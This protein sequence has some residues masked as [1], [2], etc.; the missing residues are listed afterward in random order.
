MAK[1]KGRTPEELSRDAAVVALLERALQLN[2]E[3]CFARAE[4]LAPCPIGVEGLCCRHCAMGP[5]RLVGKAERGVCGATVDTVVARNFARAVAAGA[6]AHSDHGRDLAF[7]LLEA[8]EGQ[9]S[10]YRIRDPFKLKEVA[11]Y[12]GVP[13][14]G[15]PIRDI[16]RD[17]ALAALGE[18]GRTHGELLY[19][20]RAPAKRQKI[21]RDLHIAPRAIDREVVELLHRTNIGNDQDPEHLLD[22]A[23]RC[24]LADGWG[25]S[26][27]ATDLTD[28]LFG[29]PA[30]VL[31]EANL[32]VLEED[33]VNIIIH[34]HEPTL[35]EMI[36]AAAQD[37]ELI[38][39]ARSKGAT[40]INL[41][42]ICCTA[43]EALMRQGVPLAGNFL[44]QELAILTG[45]VEAMVVDV[46]CIMQGLVP[47]ASRFHTEIITT[48]RKAKIVG[49]TH[50]EFDE[51]RA[52]EIAKEIIRR[53]IDR[54]PLRDGV[55]IPE[56]RTPLVPGFS[57]E[58]IGYALGGFYRGSFRPLNDAII[59]GRI[60]GVVANIGC[61][62]ARVCHDELHRYV[63]S[64]FLKNDV[65]VVETGCGA[66]AGAKAGF[67]RPEA[68]LELAGPGLR[69]VCEAVGIPPVLHLGACVDNSRILTVLS[70]MAT[71]T[72]LGED[73][74]D[75]PAVGMAPEWMSEKALAIATYCVASGAYVIMGG[76]G[77][78]RG[79]AEVTRLISEGWEKKVGGK[80]EF[81]PDA[82]EIVRRALAH[83]DQKRAALGLA[84]YDPSKWGKSGDWRIQ[85]ILALPLEARLEAI[86]GMSV[87]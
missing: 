64:E 72:G 70:Q 63:V 71:E 37:P 44:Q 59:A 66:I 27:L 48:S 56:A 7:T 55:F 31:S 28:I 23:M 67:M 53:A 57:H 60:R 18:F 9:A 74:A 81:I 78:V 79:S 10:D 17:V 80:L 62:N 75:I 12:L 15:R 46:Q 47:I 1:K 42:G 52:L 33:M 87:N 34:G 4:E 13:V 20:K 21:W 73:I 14:D 45:A 38:E 86:Y 6:A 11:G 30:P 5:C 84:K 82:E 51:R 25:G 26:M 83:I 16:A 3:T 8:A 69:E 40:G 36:V 43:N 61:N 76:E 2:M 35:S 24:A 77:P 50:I 32:G 49:A 29:T 58:Y 22:Q 85:E 54:F 41:A 65:L 19:L 68:A 39:Y